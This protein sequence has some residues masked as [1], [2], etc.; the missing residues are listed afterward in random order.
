VAITTAELVWKLSKNT[1]PGNSSAQANPNDSIGGFMSST[2][3]AGGVLGDLFDIIS[4]D[5]NAA[6]T[7]DYRLVFVHNTNA[8]LALQNPKV[9]I[10]SETGGGANIAI[11]LD[12][13]GITVNNSASAQ[14]ERIANEN[15]APSGETFSSPTTKGAGLS[16]ANIPAGSVLPIWIRR[17]ATN[18]AAINS[19]DVV[20]RLEGDTTA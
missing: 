10:F 3:W 17:T 6:S 11:A 19:D 7:V 12:G 14:A 20:I 13:T 8:S 1:G 9:W 2:T 18:S 15:T 5:E 4:G 16:P